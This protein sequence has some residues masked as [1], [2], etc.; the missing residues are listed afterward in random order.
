MGGGVLLYVRKDIPSKLLKFKYDNDIECIIIEIS[1]NKRKW[2]ILGLYNAKGPNITN[3][4]KYVSK[5]LDDYFSSYENIIILGDFNVEITDTTLDEFIGLYNLKCLV[6]EPTC[7]ESLEKPSCIDLILTNRLHSFQDTKVLETGISDFHKLTVSVLKTSF[8]K[9]PPKIVTY[10]DYNKFSQVKFREELDQLIYKPTIINASNDEFVNTFMGVFNKHAPIKSKILRANDNPFMT[11]ELRKAIMVRSRL[12]NDLNKKKTLLCKLAYNKQRHFCT[13]LLR[14]TKKEYYSKLSP[15]NVSDNKKFWKIVKPFFSDKSVTTDKIT[16]IDDNEIH[17]DDKNVS[18]IFNNFFSNAVNNLNIP[19]Y[20]PLNADVDEVDPIMKAINKYKNHDSIIRIREETNNEEGFSF[21]QIESKTVENAIFSLN[22]SKAC[23][24]NSIPPH[25]IKKNCDIFVPRITSDINNSIQDCNFPANLK[26]ADITPVFKKGD[27]LDTCNYRPVSILPSLSK[28][29][30]RIM[31]SQ[32]NSYMNP[33]LSMYL[34]G[35][36]KN[37]SAQNCLLVMLEKFRS[38]LDNK[39]SCGVLLT[40]LSKAFDCLN[41][42][43]LIAKL[44]SYGFDFKSLKLIN[45][46]LTDRKQRVRVNSI[47]SSWSNII[48]GVPQGSILGPLLFNIYLNDIFLFFKNSNIA[49][50][51]DDNSPVACKDNTDHVILQLEND[52]KTLLNWVSQN[53]LKAN[54]DKFHLLLSDSNPEYF[55]KVEDF[56][57]LNSTNKKLLGITI[58]NKLS[59]DEHVGLLCNKASQKLHALARISHYMDIKQRQIIMKSFINS[60]FGY[61][62]IVWMFHSR[63]MNNRINKIHERS[64]R[65]VFN[66]NASSFRELLIKDNS[67]T[68]HERNIQNLAIELYKI[69]NGF[70]PDIMSIVFP[71]KENIK[72]CSKNKFLTRNVRTVNYGTETLAHLGPKIWAIIPDDIKDEKSVNSFKTRIKNWRPLTCP[73]KLCKTYISGVGY[74]D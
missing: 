7:F 51:A 46:Y 57:I 22:K 73:C 60:Q 31:F 2:L 30:E 18:E 44:N 49:N 65:I 9:Q 72:Y 54:P 58:D 33:K 40:D 42:E 17:D 27:R 26:N 4:L 21:K 52:S 59:F 28:V 63:K 6:K 14:R 34:C 38:C 70:S 13:G 23:P 56:D 47:Y 8:K 69:V 61:C 20:I 11:K 29:F 45:S 19:E 37:M 35:F 43:L 64:L 67:V 39:G 3:C 12:H 15:K 16:I 71:V 10:R 5:N 53:G 41:H 62:P 25:I 48:F 66:D 1:I 32:I 50:Y 36:R 55:V 74:I 68:I 24:S